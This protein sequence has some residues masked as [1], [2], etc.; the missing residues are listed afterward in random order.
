ML[1]GT[2]GMGSRIS[3]YR[4]EVF[5]QVELVDV[6]GDVVDVVFVNHPVC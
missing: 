2:V 5:E 6:P 4:L 1:S 3:L